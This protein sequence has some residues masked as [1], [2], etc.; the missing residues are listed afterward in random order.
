M[1]KIGGNGFNCI[2]NAMLDLPLTRHPPHK[3]LWTDW[4]LGAKVVA[5]A[6]AIAIPSPRL[7]VEMGSC[8][9]N[10]VALAFAAQHTRA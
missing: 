1:S 7:T 8:L 9:Q 2:R 10:T 6:I 3:P 5:F 4:G